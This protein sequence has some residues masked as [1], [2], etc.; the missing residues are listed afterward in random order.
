MT[1]VLTIGYESTS[2]DDFL[3]MLIKSKVGLI[4]DVRQVAVSRR[5]G[6]SKT[7]LAQALTKQRIAYSHLRDLGDPKPG[8]E[9]ARAGRF[10]EFVKI[11]EQHLK[12]SAAQAQLVE[13]EELVQS[14]RACLLCY[15]GDP[16][17]CHRTI[18]AA[19]LQKRIGCTVEHIFAVPTARESRR[20][21]ESGAAR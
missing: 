4:V 19:R 5:K 16:T 7:A 18:V 2:I 15:E 6:F 20:A 1:S 21:R 14:N 11:Y 10:D 8:R 17:N 3:R 13:L 9:A 12:T